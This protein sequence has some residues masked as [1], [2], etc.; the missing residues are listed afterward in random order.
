MFNAKSRFFISTV[1]LMFI[2]LGSGLQV[3]AMS[4]GPI[5]EKKVQKQEVKSKAVPKGSVRIHYKR[6]DDN[7]DGWGLHV[8]GKG[9]AGPKVSWGKPL[10]ITGFNEYGA[11]WDIPYSGKG[12]LNF[13]IHK[14]NKKD[15]NGDRTYPN[16]NKNKEIWTVSGDIK[17]YLSKEK[18]KARATNK[19]EQA[20]IKGQQTIEVSFKMPVDKIEVKNN[21]KLVD[22]AKIDRSKAPK[23]VIRTKNKLD[24]NKDYKVKSGDISSKTTLSAQVIDK[25]YAYDGKLGALYSP[26]ETTFKLWAPLASQV[27]LK[28]FKDGADQKPYKIVKANKNN[29][30]VWSVTI[31]GDLKEEFYQYDVTNNGKTKTILDP[32]AKS[33]AGFN[34]NT[35]KIGKAAVV[36]LE[37]TD[38]K[39]W[40]EREY[41]N[42]EDPEDVVIYEVSVRDFTSD[43]ESGVAKEKRGTYT[44]FI[45]KIPYLKKLGVT[46]VQLLPVL[47]FYYGNEFNKSFEKKGSKGE[48]NYNWGYDPHNYFTPEGWYSQ[49]PSKPHL[50]VKE[51][52]KLV[53]ALHDAGIGVMLDVVY[54]HTANTDIF[55]PIVPNYYYRHKADGTLSNASFCGNETASERAMMRKLIIDST[56]YWVEEYNIDGFRFD[57]MGIHDEKTMRLVDRAIKKINPNAVIHGEGWNMPTTLSEEREYIKGSGKEHSLLEI[58]FGTGMFNDSY[59]DAIKHQSYASPL[60]E[61]G[62]IQGVAGKEALV[63]AGVIAGMDKFNSEI[64]VNEEEYNRFADDPAEVTSYVTCHDGY[65]L[66]DKVVGSTPNATLEERKRIDKLAAAMIFTAQGRSFLHAGA[67]MLRSKPN[68]DRKHG[69]DHN[70]YDSGDSVNMIDWSRTEKYADVVDYYQGL[71]KLRMKHDAFRME[72]M[73]EINKGI[74]FLNSTKNNVVAYKLAEQNG[75]DK[76]DEII[77]IY[78]SNRTAKTIS[79][80]DVDSSWKVVVDGNQAGVKELTDT[81]V[82]VKDGKVKVPAIAAVVL[83][84]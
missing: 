24:Y 35:D 29:K 40:E 70:S 7:Y 71:I 12:K 65:T 74:T 36:D 78:N 83:H 4:S 73:K 1:L 58:K 54:N 52:K 21:G 16:P 26:Q 56:T 69:V 42:I 37:E 25:A 31:A 39:G 5:K 50:R 66:W 15:P 60:N 28:L 82:E 27:K 14:G 19:I 6:F 18:A 77:V 32:Y 11:Y 53:Q 23:Y 79:L 8:W 3:D 49:D 68:T 61:G 34:S 20:M 59:R 64:P 46:H 44:G 33:M 76:W 51:L 45:E 62:F 63:R 47:N 10:K 72:T 9:Y 55:A 2:V 41:V 84:N 48:A 81:A 80:S 75:T 43:P 38:P 57:L 67:E 22:I 17:E 13:I 30:G